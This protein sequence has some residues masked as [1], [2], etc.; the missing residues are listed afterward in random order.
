M[1][2]V[3][4]AQKTEI[5]KIMFA[6]TA[7][8]IQTYCVNAQD[9]D[10]TDMYCGDIIHNITALK[11]FENTGDLDELYNNIMQQDTLVREYYIQ[12][13]EAIDSIKEENFE[14]SDV[15]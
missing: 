14:F 13:L 2:Q 10:N 3:T 8:Y 12:V 7:Q 5:A 1:Q 15:E 11:Q 4:A 6:I 9:S